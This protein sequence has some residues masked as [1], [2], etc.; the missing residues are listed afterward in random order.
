[1]ALG[2]LVRFGA[3]YTNGQA[4]ML[5]P[6]VHGNII[7]GRGMAQVNEVDQELQFIPPC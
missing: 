6:F 7:C 4:D 2:D 5:G 3:D 1:M